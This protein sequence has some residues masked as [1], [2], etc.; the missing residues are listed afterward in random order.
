MG[1]YVGD[2]NKVVWCHESGTYGS[3]VSTYPAN[4]SPAFWPG[5][6]M[7]NDLTEDMG[8]I[9]QRYCGTNSRNVGQ[10]IDGVINLDGTLKIIPQSWKLL[11][12]VLGSCVDTSG[13]ICTHVISEVN[14]DN[15]DPFN[16]SNFT[17]FQLQDAQQTLV[18][19]SGLNMIRS[20]DG[21]EVKTFTL[22]ITEGEPLNFEIGYVAH[23]A[24]FSSGATWP[25]TAS[26]SIPYLWQEC[27]FDLPSGTSLSKVKNMTVTVD[28]TPESTH[29]VGTGR[30]I[31]E[32]IPTN[33]NYEISA[34]FHGNSTWGN[35][36]YQNYLLGG[37]TFNTQLRVIK[38][39][40]SNQ[41]I[42]TFSGCKL[43][44]MSMPTESE[45]VNEWALTIKPQTSSITVNDTTL[46]YN[47]W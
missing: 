8:V 10:F 14:S 2:Q 17:S 19:A 26:T 20:I 42:W 38:T 31:G 9:D 28:N 21:C 3:G 23:Q 18:A 1:V 34:T 37:S 41:M 5:M 4:G 45:G 35:T 16:A 30:Q 33:R 22:N 46:L 24:I 32:P 47:P 44:D 15:V 27:T 7:S 39:A 43:T 12:F 11:K 6:V 13:T 36:L 29:Y 40:S 25:V